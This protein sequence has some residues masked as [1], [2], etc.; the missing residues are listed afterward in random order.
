MTMEGIMPNSETAVREIDA[1]EAAA[2][3]AAQAGREDE[4]TR[5]WG[6]IL[7][8]DPNHIR[9]L[10]ALGQRSFRKGD[11]QSARVAF[12]RLAELDGSDARRW[13]HLALACRGLGDSEAEEKAIRSAL[14][15]DPTDLVALI[16]R[17]DFVERQ[18]KEHEAA[19][20]HSRVAAVAPPLERLRPELRPGVS[21]ALEFGKAYN[22]RYGSFLD[23]F[24]EPYFREFSGENLRRFR[25]S[26]DIMV[27][28]KR[29][30]DSH[31]VVYHFPNL[32]PIEFFERAGF[33]WLD[34]IEAE[35]D[36]IRNELLD[37]LRSEEGFTPYI[38]YPPEVPNH[39]WEELNNSPRWS[40][41]HLYKLGQV[42]EANAARC[43]VTMRALQGAPQ[44]DQPGRSPSAM[45]SSIKP[46][47]RIP[48]HIGATNTRL[49]TH[50]PLIIPE[51]CGFRVGNETRQW[52]P[53]RAWVF[54]DT[55]EHEMW[56]D[57]DEPHVV[58]AFDIWHPQLTP[59]ERAMITAL[60]AGIRAFS[61][62]AGGFEA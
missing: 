8:L 5:L 34:S 30:F 33:P 61:A 47:T 26:V 16:L 24:L 42:L 44:P 58:L 54:D 52:E 40:A 48:P 18:G 11:M 43:P 55:I 6:K 21:R 1:L 56:N 51:G 32:A 23:E 14:T 36:E 31:S 37:I 13:I 29:R 17:A 28:R 57:S 50:L 15:L 2:V 45:F 7:S 19:V 27:G 39:P 35:T 60:A 12:Q 46:K 25:D 38:S 41:F 62:G 22:Q 4:A 10:T 49:L 20:A 59:P 53:G 3:R 9:T